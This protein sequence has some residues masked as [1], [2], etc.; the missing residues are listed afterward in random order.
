MENRRE[1]FKREF[2]KSTINLNT[3]VKD[4]DARLLSKE[5]EK[6]QILEAAIPEIEALSKK[7]PLAIDSASRFDKLI[8]AT[9]QYNKQH[10]KMGD[11]LRLHRR[12]LKKQLQLCQSQAKLVAQR[13]VKKS[14]EQ[15]ASDQELRSDVNNGEQDGDD[16]MDD[17]PDHS[18]LDTF[19]K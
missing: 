5:V 17:K 1:E 11:D 9:A 15:S 12:I 14:I 3:L 19:W 16:P 4:L 18:W 8:K 13:L 7:H 6:A 2:C 10:A